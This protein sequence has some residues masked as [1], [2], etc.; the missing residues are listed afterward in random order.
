MPKLAEAELESFFAAAA[1]EF[2]RAA[3]R[4]AVLERELRFGDQRVRLRFAG[5]EL[6]E[7]LLRAFSDRR[8]DGEGDPP[9]TISVWEERAI[10][11]GSVPHPWAAVDIGPGGLVRGS[12]MAA[13]RPYTTPTGAR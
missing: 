6:A 1:V 10:V 8:V 5:H 12:G 4:E 11:G 9:A 7:V 2:E 3:R 13:W